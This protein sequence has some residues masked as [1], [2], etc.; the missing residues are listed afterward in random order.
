MGFYSSW[1]L[2]MRAYLPTSLACA[3]AAV[4]L[5][6]YALASGHPARV[7]R[8]VLTVGYSFY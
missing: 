3:L 6:M 5:P 4:Q 7:G 1:G 2:S 8:L